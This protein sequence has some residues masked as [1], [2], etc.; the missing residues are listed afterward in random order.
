MPSVPDREDSIL[1]GLTDKGWYVYVYVYVYVH[2]CVL[3]CPHT[4]VGIRYLITCEIVFV[5][6][7]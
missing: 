4:T 3:D 7:A 6:Q 2:V 5:A 1:S